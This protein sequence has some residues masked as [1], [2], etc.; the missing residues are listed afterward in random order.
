MTR[1]FL[2]LF[3]AGSA[4]ATAVAHPVAPPVQT[5]VQGGDQFLDGIGETGLIARYLFNGNAEDSSRNQLHATV[6]GQ[7]GVFVDDGPRKVLLLTG[8][9]SHAQLPAGSLGG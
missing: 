1:P 7:G 8:D 5:A 4:I 3:L 2:L 6:R 9:G